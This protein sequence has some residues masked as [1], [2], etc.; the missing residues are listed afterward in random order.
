MEIKR[1]DFLK[2]FGVASG[3]VVL[4]GCGLDDTF[5]LPQ[6]ILDKAGKGPGIETWKNTVCSLCPGG[7]G[8]RVRLVDGIPVY[9]KGNPI[10]PLNQG[11]MCPLGLN[12]LHA[13]YNPDR[14]SGPLRRVGEPGEGK[15]ESIQW[16]NALKTLSDTLVKLRNEGKSHQVVFLGS[17][18]RG[19]MH[20]HVARFMQ[21]F[22]SPN[23]YQF[24]S[25]QND[26]VPYSLVQ[27]RGRIPSYDFLN[28][29]LILSFGSNFLEEGY[30]PVY[31]T[32]LYSDHQERGTRYIQIEPRL[33]LTASNADRWVP[34]R[35]G[36]YG[37][38]ALGIAYVLIREELCDAKFVS[39][40][41]H[42]FEDWRDSRGSHVGFKNF[43]L[44]NYYPEKVSDITGVP[45][46]TILELAREVGQTKP[47]LVL[48]DQGAIDNTNGT[49]SLMAIH[50]LNALLGNFEREG[51][52]F[53]VQEPSFAKLPPLQVDAASKR[54]SQQAPLAQ[55]RDGTFPLTNFS[56]ESFTKNILADDPY[57]VSVLFLYRGNPVFQSIDSQAFANALKKI[58]LVVSF[59][60][61][62]NETS[63]YAHLVL[64]EHTFLEGWNEISNVPSVGFT[65]IGIQ[66]PVVAP[67]Y[68]TRHTG[69]VIIQLAKRAGGSVASAFP[70]ENYGEILK[71]RIKGVFDSGEGAV[72]SE[73][74]KGLWLQ[75]LQQRGWHAGR[76]ESYDDFWNQLLERGG[77]WN[78]VRKQKSWQEVF[79]TPSGKFEFFSQKLQ[80]AID[81]L[82]KIHD[83]GED[84]AHRLDLV[85]NGLNITARGDAVCLPHH[86]PVP[87]DADMPLHLI[88][89]QTL[90]NRDG[91]G[92]D[93][94]MMQEMFGYQ[95]RE[96]WNSWVEIHPDTAAAY[97]ITDNAVVRLESSVG[98]LKVHAKLNHGI[99]PNVV[100]V[101]FG[102]GHTSYGRYAKG[103]GVNPNSIMRKSYDLISGKPATEATKVRVTLVT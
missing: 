98:S 7:C 90:S 32:K 88:T 99:M 92:S 30:S 44:G 33:S 84:V 40:Q 85:L 75:Y 48:G 81:K 35:P 59:D 101:P 91:Q 14:V 1:R 87:Y 5:A 16:D 19:L 64:P 38:L 31:Y 21:A 27:G 22:G 55:A 96:W 4:A 43:V 34:I 100:A 45:S 53:F 51:G 13:L 29:R 25:L 9:V 3:A 12:A 52:V 74:M 70:F 8:I 28:A 77:W 86:E 60:S 78:P 89:F 79:E 103:F 65:H 102:M 42:G 71:E 18:E 72:I 67:L 46:Q 41:T 57:P 24:S 39:A 49:F 50:S 82:I 15:W 20:E 47:A 94:P 95:W 10:H 17:D 26:E 37:A 36:T 69:D 63:E 23:Y 61:V 56:I 2:L 54:G 66:Q 97:G 80:T 68:D 6:E 93:L 58:P 83:Q 73:G 62:I 76:Y 11:G